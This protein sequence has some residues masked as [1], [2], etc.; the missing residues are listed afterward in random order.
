[1]RCPPG[2]SSADIPRRSRATRRWKSAGKNRSSL[3]TRTWV[4]TSGHALK[5]QGDPNTVSDWRGSP[6]AQALSTTGCGTS[7]KKSMGGS[8]SKTGFELPP[9]HSP[10]VASHS[11]YDSRAVAADKRNPSIGAGAKHGRALQIL[12]QVCA[13]DP[14]L[15]SEKTSIGCMFRL[16]ANQMEGARWRNEQTCSQGKQTGQ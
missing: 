12:S 13:D 10:V 16:R 8:N 5:V 14:A 2:I 7:W 15:R 4:G 11:S 9:G 1:M 6:F 3:P